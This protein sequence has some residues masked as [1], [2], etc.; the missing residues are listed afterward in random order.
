MLCV[1]LPRALRPPAIQHASPLT[2]SLT[3]FPVWPYLV[4]F[5][6]VT[7][8][9]MHPGHG[10]GDSFPLCMT[11]S[12]YLYVCMFPL[13]FFWLKILF[14]SIIFFPRNCTFLFP[15]SPITLFQVSC[16]SPCFD[17]YTRLH[18]AHQSKA[19]Q[20]TQQET[21]CGT[22]ITGWCWLFCSHQH[23]LHRQGVMVLH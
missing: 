11:F 21:V 9:S 1:Y 2:L 3:F 6:P 17:I 5:K 19:L 22:C 16:W 10:K 13:G 8:P 4:G 7:S 15:V 18:V 20:G 12:M 14:Q 23:H